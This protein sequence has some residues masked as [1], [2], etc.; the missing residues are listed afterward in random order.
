M[1]ELTQFIEQTPLADTHDHVCK[2]SEYVENGPDILCQL[3]KNYIQ[4]DLMVARASGEAVTRLLDSSNPDL[5]CRFNGIREAWE[6]CRY[7]G[8]G[9]A[10]RLMAKHLY[11]M[12]EITLPAIEKAQQ[13]HQEL[14]QPG[15]RLHILRD[16][17]R[18]DHVQIDTVFGYIP[19]ETNQDFFFYDLSLYSF[20]SG[21]LAWIQRE[22]GASPITSLKAL[23]QAMADLFARQAPY[24]I[25]VKSQHAYKRTLQWRERTDEEAER[26]LLNQLINHSCTP[27]DMICL[28]DWCLERGVELSIE[29]NLPFKFHTGFGAGL[30]YM[31]IDRMRAAHLCSLLQKYPAAKFVLMHLSY[32]YCDELIALAKHYL[33]VYIDFCWGWSIDPYSAQDSLRRMIHTVPINKIFI[34][35]GD[36]GWPGTTLAYSIQ[37]R[38]GLNRAL[39]AEIDAGTFNEAEAI[40][41]ARRLMNTNQKECFD[42]QGVCERRRTRATLHMP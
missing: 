30:G 3:F 22:V 33:N 2:E 40:V 19:D 12:D 39:Q 25:A 1:P 24:S 16:M 34:F 13:R 42:L 23:R 41:V 6:R 11:G 28:G 7:T 18:L 37:A 26:A 9:E 17:G 4:T 29:Y 5:A 38:R 36:A 14:R 10:V 20:C 27:E 15:W 8:Y 21:E 32:P 31:Q 35:G